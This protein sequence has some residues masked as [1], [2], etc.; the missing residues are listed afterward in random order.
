MPDF[1]AAAHSWSFVSE[2]VLADKER[3]CPTSVPFRD[4]ARFVREK[5]AAVGGPLPLPPKLQSLPGMHGLRAENVVEDAAPERL[6]G[7]DTR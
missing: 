5:A 7:I 2:E 3:I 6:Q 1:R 4:I